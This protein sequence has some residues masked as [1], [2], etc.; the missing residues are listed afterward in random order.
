MNKLADS[1]RRQVMGT[2]LAAVV[3]PSIAAA[4]PLAAAVVPAA[5]AVVPQKASSR[6]EPDLAYEATYRQS[7][8]AIRRAE[9]RMHQLFKDV[10]DR[11]GRSDVA[12]GDLV[13]MFDATEGGQLG[14]LNNWV[15][16]DERAQRRKRTM[17]RRGLIV[18]AHKAGRYRYVLTKEGR[19]ILNIVSAALAAQSLCADRIGGLSI[20]ALDHACQTVAR[21]ERW[22]VDI[23]R[24]KL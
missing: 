4:V 16:S 1:T 7:F 11:A 18:G 10:L 23:V 2:A 22:W 14:L 13:I 8:L 17:V 19:E 3:A 20:G 6:I 12:A 21:T 24:Y 15:W 5:A 9:M